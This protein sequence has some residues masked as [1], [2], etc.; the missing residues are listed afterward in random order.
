MAR[1]IEY[2][3]LV[4]R[5]PRA[6]KKGG[7]EEINAFITNAEQE[8]ESMFAGAYTI[9]FSSNNV[10]IKDLAVDLTYI[11]LDV[12]SSKENVER[13]KRLMKTVD[14]IKTNKMQMLTN[15]GDIVGAA[16]PLWSN[17]TDYH[18]VHG[19]LDVTDQVVDDTRIQDEIDE[20]S[21]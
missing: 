4:N 18:P 17:T 2:D 10:T 14:M 9:P 1:Y 15:S 8:L 16:S 20:R 3:D 7:Q 6:S 21:D 19:V 11:K 12:Q 5:Y 13:H